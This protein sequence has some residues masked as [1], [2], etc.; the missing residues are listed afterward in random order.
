MSGKSLISNHP[1]T[2]GSLLPRSAASS[3][4]SN[5]PMIRTAESDSYPSQAYHWMLSLGWVSF[6]AL[7]ACTYVTVND[8]TGGEPRHPG[9]VEAEFRVGVRAAVQP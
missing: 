3:N 4:Q 9:M 2:N 6:L 1:A 8:A 5:L 7:I